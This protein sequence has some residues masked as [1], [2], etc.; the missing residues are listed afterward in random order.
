M[1][2][3]RVSQFAGV[4]QERAEISTQQRTNRQRLLDAM[5][6]GELTVCSR[7]WWRFDAP[8]AHVDRPIRDVPVS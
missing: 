5:S 3:Y 8:G 1:P 7:E 2:G 6:A 4:E